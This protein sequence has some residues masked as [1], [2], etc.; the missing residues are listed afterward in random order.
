MPGAAPAL[1]PAAA[2]AAGEAAGAP[3]DD[4]AAA[5]GA[6]FAG[7]AVAFAST[8]AEENVGAVV[9]APDAVVLVVAPVAPV[10]GVGITTSLLPQAARIAAPAVALAPTRNRR[11]LRRIRF[12]STASLPFS[13]PH[14]HPRS[15]PHKTYDLH[16]KSKSQTFTRKC[17]GISLPTPTC[18]EAHRNKGLR[19]RQ[20]TPCIRIKS[21]RFPKPRAAHMWEARGIKKI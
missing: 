7:A 8:G 12:S 6:V 9:G 4:A 17:M 18:N 14:S 16:K 5:V 3:A 20:Q 13:I 19:E 1:V 15:E 21:A 2:L 11:R 10:V